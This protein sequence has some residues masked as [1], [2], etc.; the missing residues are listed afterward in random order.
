[1]SQPLQGQVVPPSAVDLSNTRFRSNP[2]YELVLFDR[3]SHEQ[4]GALQGLQDD[5]GFY[6]ILRPRHEASLGIKSVDQHTA[7]LYLTMQRAGP[8][9]QYVRRMLGQRAAD[10]MAEL[11]LDGVLEMEHAGSFVSGAAA[12]LLLAARQ[13]MTGAANRNAALSIEALKYGQALAL[14]DVQQLS[15]WLYGYNRAPLTPAWYHRLPT[16][17][18]VLGHLGLDRTG[19]NARFLSK[20]WTA[21]PANSTQTGW[22]SWRLRRLGQ[23]EH[24]KTTTY[25]LYVSPQAEH[26]GAAFEALIAAGNGM[27]AFAFKVGRDVYG[28]LRPDKLVAYFNS[29]EDLAESADHLRGRL[30]GCPAQGVPFTAGITPDGLLSWGRDPPKSAQTPLLKHGESWRLWLTN[31]LAHALVDAQASPT[32]QVEPWEFAL[33]RLKLEDVDTDT[34]TPAGNIWRDDRA[35]EM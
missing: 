10:A 28:L 29:F 17:D 26:I 32:R 19:P 11:V 14:T 27:K 23:I 18:A 9:P 7:L 30:D 33:H 4:Q 25:K 15:H 8:L 16:P 5:P 20:R 1:M 6:G 21:V 12:T 13:P 24:R 31:R 34:W 2:G 22:L 35:A 3:L